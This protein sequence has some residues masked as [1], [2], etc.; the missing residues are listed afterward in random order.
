MVHF[1]QFVHLFCCSSST[2]FLK[3][4]SGG[5]ILALNHN[6]F[7]LPKV[8]QV[9][10]KGPPL[11]F[12]GTL[13]LFSKI[14]EDHQRV[15]LAF[16]KVSVCKKRLMGLNDLFLGFSALCDFNRI[17]LKKI[18]FLQMLPIVVFGL[19]RLFFAN[20]SNVSK[21]FPF[22]FSSFS[23]EWMFKN[24]QMPPFTFV[25]TM[26]LTE[27]QKKFKKKFKKI[28]SFLFFP[29]VGFVKENT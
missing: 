16:F 12:F 1:L 28:Q 9:R 13:R 4:E 22:I 20:F 26:R 25:G 15:P 2:K 17:L 5:S 19:V 18:F 11:G 21:R 10:P 29:H 23:K 27:D 8:Q 3:P 14:F 6:I 7:M 24:S